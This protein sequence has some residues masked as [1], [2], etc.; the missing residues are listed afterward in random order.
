MPVVSGGI[1]SLFVC[2]F[3]AQSFLPLLHAREVD[4]KEMQGRSCVGHSGT[5]LEKDPDA[6]HHQSS[7]CPVCQ[8]LHA[9]QPVAAQTVEK[10]V[11][12]PASA[13]AAPT[14]LESP[15]SHGPPLAG[16]S[17]RAPPDAL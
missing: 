10:I 1:L 6:S 11:L 9:S 14:A 3:L 12:E 16:S 2:A 7:S 5:H 4:A 8:T 17:P 15:H 13:A